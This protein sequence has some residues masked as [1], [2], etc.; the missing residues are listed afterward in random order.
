MDNA[1]NNT[2]CALTSLN[3]RL[4][5][6]HLNNYESISFTTT[7]VLFFE[8]IRRVVHR[9]IHSNGTSLMQKR[10]AW[11]LQ[12]HGSPLTESGAQYVIDRGRWLGSKTNL[13][14]T[15][16]RDWQLVGRGDRVSR[17][18]GGLPRNQRM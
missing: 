13:Q 14:A 1:F 12:V 17:W 2:N 7:E 18:N 4:A 16:K 5:L 11:C 10:S 6:L 15:S 9:F 3:L 8:R